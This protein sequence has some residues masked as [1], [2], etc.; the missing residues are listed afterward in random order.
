V[1]KEVEEEGGGREIGAR[2]EKEYIG[3]EE[4]K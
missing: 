4:E 1:S 2:E 3:E